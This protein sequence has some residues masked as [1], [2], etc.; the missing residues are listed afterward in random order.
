MTQAQANKVLKAA[1]GRAAG[2]VKM[3]RASKGRHGATH[4]ATDTGELACGNKPKP[5]PEVTI[6]DV[7]AELNDTWVDGLQHAPGERGP[8]RGSYSGPLPLEGSRMTAS[9][10]RLH[11]TRQ[12]EA[13]CLRR[14]GHDPDP[15]VW[16]FLSNRGPENRWS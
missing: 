1:S 10:G 4:A 16:V 13:E 8:V 2:F 11:A 5:H 12:Y 7:S 9:P 14:P 3:V 6:T 15:I